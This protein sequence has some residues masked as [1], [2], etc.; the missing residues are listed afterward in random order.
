M[1]QNET[2]Q[3][4]LLTM[5]ETVFESNRNSRRNR[6]ESSVCIEIDK[7]SQNSKEKTV[8]MSSISDNDS[9]RL[10]ILEIKKETILE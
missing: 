3:N 6:D 2:I 9:L 8:T 1:N 7:T 10:P 4:V 5:K